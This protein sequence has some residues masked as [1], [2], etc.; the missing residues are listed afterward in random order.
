MG[1]VGC[2][3]FYLLFV[4]SSLVVVVV[5]VATAICLFSQLPR[6]AASDFVMSQIVERGVVGWGWWYFS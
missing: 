5:V 6:V 3:L 4:S 2:W 1:G